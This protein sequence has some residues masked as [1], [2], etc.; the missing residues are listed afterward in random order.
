MQ[1]EK[2]MLVER[3]GGRILVIKIWII[4][5][6]LGIL[7]VFVRNLLEYRIVPL[8]TSLK[9]VLRLK[10]KCINYHKIFIM[11]V[12]EGLLILFK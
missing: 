12:F 7:F 3:E 4:R 10:L 1:I 5:S 8:I 11:N 2:G 9:I 6:T